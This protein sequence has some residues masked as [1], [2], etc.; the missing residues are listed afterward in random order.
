MLDIERDRLDA[1]TGGF[2]MGGTSRLAQI[3]NATSYAAKIGGVVAGFTYTLNW[4]RPSRTAS[5]KHGNP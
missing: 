1:V 2:T 4:L 5:S 3:V